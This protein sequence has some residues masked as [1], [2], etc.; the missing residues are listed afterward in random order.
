[1][2]DT[3]WKVR[4]SFCHRMFWTATEISPVRL[5]SRRLLNQ[6]RVFF[7]LRQFLQNRL[8][9][10]ASKICTQT[11][12]SLNFSFS[13]LQSAH[14]LSHKHRIVTETEVP[15]T[16]CD[17]ILTLPKINTTCAL[18]EITANTPQGDRRG[19]S[20]SRFKIRGKK[21]TKPEQPEKKCSV[22]K[23]SST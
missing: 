16:N 15:H 21:K 7:R 11:L 13:K 22:P 23:P 17:Q 1:M 4:R 6:F 2:S 14:S 12:S 19:G 9:T 18:L 3:V 20:R 8:N 10:S 5:C